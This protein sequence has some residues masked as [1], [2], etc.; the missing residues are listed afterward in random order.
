MH[1]LATRARPPSEPPP[2]PPAAPVRRARGLSLIWLI[3]LVAAVIAGWLTWSTWANE[4]PAVRIT[5][6]TAEGLEAGKTK[7]KYRDVD[8]GTVE[9]IKISPDLKGVAVTAR[10]VRDAS[11]YLTTGTKFWIV[12]PRIGTAGVSG[13]GTLVS[14]AYKIGRASCRERV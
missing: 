5:F 3:P 4:G 8:V 11:P 14:G 2:P 10:M 7:I 6:E 13:L 1:D 12:R 9:N